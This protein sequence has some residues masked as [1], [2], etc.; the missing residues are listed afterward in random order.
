MAEEAAK[1]ESKKAETKYP[2]LSANF[3]GPKATFKGQL[4]SIHKR[5]EE[6]GGKDGGGAK[7]EAV[8]SF[9]Q[10]LV[11]QAIKLPTERVS[12][13]QAKQLADLGIQ[14]PEALLPAKKEAK[15]KAD[16]PAEAGA[17]EDVSD[18]V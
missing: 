10:A 16:A 11:D 7:A 15:A 14:L 2:G 5:F 1:T 9:R 4:K 12:H 13:Q 6:A 17:A 8:N 3:L 18:A